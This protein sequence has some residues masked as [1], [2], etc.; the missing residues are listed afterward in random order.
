MAENDKHID[1][2]KTTD[3]EHEEQAQTTSGGDEAL[4]I[5]GDQSEEISEEEA[6]AVLRKIDWRMVPLMMLVNTIQ[7]VDK[8][9]RFHA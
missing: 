7:L 5:L 6:K 2:L 4:K 1:V 3:V 9:V 8:N